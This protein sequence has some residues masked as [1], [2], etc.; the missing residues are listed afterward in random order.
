MREELGINS[1]RGEEEKV[2]PAFKAELE[3]HA[4]SPPHN[5]IQAW[6]LMNKRGLWSSNI[7]FGKFFKTKC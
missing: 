5:H 1:F 3:D 2:G 7:Y 6:N 4:H